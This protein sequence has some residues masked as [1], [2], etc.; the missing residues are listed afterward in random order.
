MQPHLIFRVHSDFRL[1]LCHVSRALATASI[2]KTMG[3]IATIAISG[4]RRAK[5]IAAGKDPFSESLLTCSAIYLGE[6]INEPLPDHL[7]SEDTVALLD[8]R[9]ATQDQ[10]KALRPLKVAIMED[11]GDAHECADL[12][13]Q[14]YLE[15]IRW[16]NSPGRNKKGDKPRP[17]EEQ[18]NGCRVLKGSA[19]IVLSALTPQLQTLRKQIQ[20]LSAKK[21]LV[22]FGGT[23]GADL[24][25]RAFD[26]IK[27]INEK[28]GWNGHCTLLAPGGLD[29]ADTPGISVL[30][31]IHNL[32]LRLPDF[33]AIWCACGIT[34][35]E[36]LYLGIPVAAWSQ[37]DR[38]NRIIADIALE[39]ACINMG[40]GP[41]A[42]LAIVQ[43][44]LA[45]WLGPLGQ[46]SR[47]EQSINGMTL[48][49]GSG[50]SRVA[51]E[52]WDL[53]KR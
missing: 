3:G 22:T 42:D 6:S 1:G 37:N 47:Q 48:V 53:A 28:N 7:K 43:E 33:D 10:V 17:H 34:Q 21:L 39:G 29:V 31:A 26:V 4:D 20:P 40:F 8:L 19:Y 23:D 41:E 18:R 35:A 5:L 13:F 15:G 16:N 11:D 45:N 32:T 51:Q 14:P 24:A 50:A 49:D 30:P 44:A 46:E 36:C 2:W 52:L 12:L 27:K 38:Q 25:P 9:D